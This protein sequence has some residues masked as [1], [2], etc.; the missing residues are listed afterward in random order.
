MKL[1]D[2]QIRLLNYINLPIDSEK[3]IK[4]I[5][6]FFKLICEITYKACFVGKI[7]PRCWCSHQQ[8]NLML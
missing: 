5:D 8:Q 4:D 1:N 6:S 3:R 2:F 7:K